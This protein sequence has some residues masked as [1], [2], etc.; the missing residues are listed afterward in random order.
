[1]N[2]LTI[3]LDF[4][5]LIPP[6]SR[7]EYDFLE[8]SILDEGCREAIVTWDD[9]ILDGHN[10]YEICQKH[11]IGFKIL[12]KE[13]SNEEEAKFWIIR[14]QLGRRNLSVYDRGTLALMLKP[15]I[16]KKA[17]EHE[18]LSEGKG[19]LN[20]TNPKTTPIHTREEIAKLAGTSPDTVRKVEVIEK[21]GSE[22][23]KQAARKGDISVN[24]AYKETRARKDP[25][26]KPR[27]PKIP[28]KKEEP[29]SEEFKKA[30][31]VFHAAI[32]DEKRRGW[33]KTSKQAVRQKI[34]I[35]EGLLSAW[36]AEEEE[37][38]V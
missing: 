33:K 9:I 26:P 11:S 8:Q 13:F 24:K 35:I 31:K 4:Q 1:M 23:I 38:Y 17:K 37:T 6:I 22:D 7:E 36:E 21:D 3:R 25:K 15:E 12:E 27:S 32:V 29:E 20:S 10:R 16:E 30:F 14:N 2:N 34:E 18:R 28:P 19:L 5:N